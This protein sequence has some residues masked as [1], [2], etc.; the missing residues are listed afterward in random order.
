MSNEVNLGQAGFVPQFGQMFRGSGKHS[1]L[2]QVMAL[3][4][5]TKCS[6]ENVSPGAA[7]RSPLS[8]Q[9]ILDFY[10]FFPTTSILVELSKNGQK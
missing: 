7:Q 9:G 10:R 8:D 2:V 5:S 1:C 3:A 4:Q 6:K